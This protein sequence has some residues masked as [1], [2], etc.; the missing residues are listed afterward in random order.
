M[1]D[2]S[3]I[4]AMGDMI[5]QSMM[6]I[7][8]NVG[9]SSRLLFENAASGQQL[10][11]NED[12]DYVAF[13]DNAAPAMKQVVEGLY[14]ET[15]LDLASDIEK[16]D[17]QP[18]IAASEYALEFW[19]GD[20]RTTT[21]ELQVPAI[22]LHMLGDWAVPY[23][24]MQGYAALVEEAGTT[25]LYR[26]SL[27][28]GAGHCEFTAAESSVAVEMLVQRVESGSWPDTSPEALNAAADALET[29]SDA[30]FMEFGDWQVGAY[31]RAW[32]PSN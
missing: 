2:V 20:G 12:A 29:G 28:N 32:T 5:V 1:A 7:A 4:E 31:N 13:Y 15:D 25:D 22:R 8:G 6:R 26:Q 19:S 10:S 9:G 14:A 23:T 30:R 11:G 21:G 18:R 3:D 27:V 17:A 24:L 16:I